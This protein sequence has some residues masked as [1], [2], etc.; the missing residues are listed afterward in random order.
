MARSKLG[1]VVYHMNEERLKILKW[2]A[3]ARFPV[4][5]ECGFEALDSAQEAEAESRGRALNVTIRI[6][7]TPASRRLGRA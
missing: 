5:K 3:Q 1:S 4:K 6:P 7:I 2:L